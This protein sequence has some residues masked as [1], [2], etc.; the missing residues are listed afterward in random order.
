[1]CDFFYFLSDFEFFFQA[2][3]RPLHLGQVGN[4]SEGVSDNFPN[5]SLF[6]NNQKKLRKGCVTNVLYRKEREEWYFIVGR[7]LA[8]VIQE[9]CGDFFHS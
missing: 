8:R 2:F 9:W 5:S 6:V 4:N 3:R 7:K 1:M